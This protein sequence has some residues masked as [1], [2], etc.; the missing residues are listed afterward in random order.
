MIQRHGPGNSL[1]SMLK[2]ALAGGVF[3]VASSLLLAAF[4]NIAYDPWGNAYDKCSVANPPAGGANLSGGVCLPLVVLGVLL[5]A[6]R[7]GP[8]GYLAIV[9]PSVG[10]S[11]PIALGLS[12]LLAGILGAFCSTLLPIRIGV[13]ATL[14]IYVTSLVPFMF[15]AAVMF[16]TG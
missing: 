9:V 5:F 7:I 11:I 14:L 3:G 2:P 8:A 15:F 6:L 1:F 16:D 4:A 10:S 12:A 13:V